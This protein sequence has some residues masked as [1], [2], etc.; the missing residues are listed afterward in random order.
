MWEG[1]GL[2]TCWLDLKGRDARVQSS[3]WCY[4]LAYDA[5]DRCTRLT[6]CDDSGKAKPRADGVLFETYAYDADGNK[7]TLEFHGASSNLVCTANGVAIVRMQYNPNGQEFRRRF[8]DVNGKPA[9]HKDGYAG[10]DTDYDGPRNRRKTIYTYVDSK[11]KPVMTTLGYAVKEVTHDTD[12]DE[13]VHAYYDTQGR[14]VG[15]D[16]ETSNRDK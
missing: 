2:V 14:L 6:Y 16:R 8:F 9:I 13:F 11:G 10:I 4:T 7:T 12:T 1:E 3:K 15:E 5:S